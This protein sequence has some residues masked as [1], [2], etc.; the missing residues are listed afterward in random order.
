MKSNLVRAALAAL[1]LSFSMTAAMAASD[2]IPGVDIIVRKNP[3]GL[4]VVVA[5]TDAKG[6]FSARIAEP[7]NYTLSTACHPK[8]AC[9]GYTGTV[10]FTV[11]LGAT[12]EPITVVGQEFGSR[13][14]AVDLTSGT[15]ST[16]SVGKTPTVIS[17]ML[18]TTK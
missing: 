3:G 4:A 14:K 13:A 10:T 18:R 2:P 15:T 9:L 12:P 17:G 11:T 5:T 7:G 6:K 1:A 8:T 16:F